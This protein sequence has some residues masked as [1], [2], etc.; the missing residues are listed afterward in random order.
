M[1]ITEETSSKESLPVST[2]EETSKKFL[3][4][5]TMKKLVV[6]SSY[7]RVPLKRQAVKRAYLR[8]A[9]KRL[10]NERILTC[11]HHRRDRQ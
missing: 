5:S 8:A 9:L 4:V 7:L 11:E 1:S 3:H 2:T 10:V 6:N